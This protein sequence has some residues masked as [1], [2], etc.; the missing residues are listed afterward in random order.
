MGLIIAGTGHRPDKLGGDTPE[1][2]AELRSVAFTALS[3]YPDCSEVICGMALGWDMAFGEAA[4]D[5]GLLVTAAIPF[6]EQADQWPREAR[7]RYA[8][9]LLRC[10]R[11]IY[12]SGPGYSDLKMD[13]RNRWMVD[14][15]DLLIACWNGSPGGTL[16]CMNY[17]RD[18]GRTT[19]NVWRDY[20]ALWSTR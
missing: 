20:T 16:N 17:A 7:R 18:V 4:A 1:I 2:Q 10:H 6:K 13:I 12:V 11:I 15:S 8:A 9:L 3:R 14:H 5:M 19:I